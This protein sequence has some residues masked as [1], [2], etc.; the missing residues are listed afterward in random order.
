MFTF[1][2]S[3][4][5][6]DS[7]KSK[8]KQKSFIA[9][10]STLDDKI[11][12]GR[13]SEINDNQLVLTKTVT[14]VSNNTGF[15]QRYRASGQQYIAAENI[16]SF[17]LKRKNSVLKGALIGL[18]AGAFT[19]MCIGWISGDDPVKPGINITLFGTTARQKAASYSEALGVGGALV[20]TIIGVALKKKFIIGGKKEKFR[21]LQSEIRMKLGQK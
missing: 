5:Q 10:I 4:A 19:G 18:G 12:E 8:N 6:S 21:K 3:Q 17:T 7:I 11:I 16:I 1:C 15:F 9:S 14:Y 2:V 20:G 13:L